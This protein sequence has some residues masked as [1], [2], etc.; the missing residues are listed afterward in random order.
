MTPAAYRS[1]AQSVPWYM[2]SAT[3][4]VITAA[5]VV[6]TNGQT[7]FVTVPLTAGLLFSA[8]FL[9]VLWRRRSG[10]I[11]WFE[12]GAVYAAL[13]TLYM[14]YPLAGFLV[15]NQ[16]YTPLN[17]A[18]LVMMQPRPEEIGEI[19]WLYVCHL[20]AFAI[21]YLVTRGRLPNRETSLTR[22]PLSVFISMLILY[23]GIEGFGLAIGLFYNTSAD[24]YLG[25]YL[26][27]RQLPLVFAQLF[28]HLNGVKYVLS[29]MLLAALFSRLPAS[30]PII[31]GW[32]AL[33]AAMTIVRLGSR[34]Q[35][36]LL[37]L[38]A[39]MMYDT[40]VRPLR[41][42]LVVAVAAVGLL[43]FLT[44]GV[45]RN[46]VSLG[47]PHGALNPF[48][49]ASEFESLFTNALH[50]ERVRPT[51]GELPAAFYAA[52]FAALV[53]QQFAPFTKVDRAD[54]YVNRFFP[55]YAMVGGGL[56]FG[57]ISEAV[58]MGGWLA[59]LAGG[60]ALGFCFASIHRL[61]VREGH[62]FWIF[63]FYVWITTLSYQSF[64][65]GTFA[66][67]VLFVYRFIPAVILVTVIAMVVRPLMIRD[68]PSRSR[69]V[70]EA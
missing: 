53:P 68:R 15:L 24:T 20:G 30:R 25:T 8:A 27:A 16:H 35:L 54:W 46:G 64:R 22:P 69:R 26:A 3:V 61:Y 51:I 21:A 58:L 43:G 59:A 70:A 23:V 2:W 57:S 34:T 66:L 32:L 39:A 60:A 50:L 14:A 67:L 63:V 33:V 1:A 9:W 56:A 11:P 18:R 5:F 29:L 45:I 47:S 4:V 49:Y 6:A 19:A 52:D 48:A 7:L 28:N 40:L 31:V 62:R 37:V 42:R 44:F 36:V 38:A 13:V 55:E 65:N 41:P 17:D 10:A 12:I